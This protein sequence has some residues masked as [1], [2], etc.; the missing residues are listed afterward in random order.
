MSGRDSCVPLIPHGLAGYS[1][2]QSVWGSMP[3][4]GNMYGSREAHTG[5][6]SFKSRQL[7]MWYKDRGSAVGSVYESPEILGVDQKSSHS[8]HSEHHERT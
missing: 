7:A 1:C 5:R 8:V 6:F 2:G 4:V 3:V